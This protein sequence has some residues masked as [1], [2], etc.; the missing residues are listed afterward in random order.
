[1]SS[2]YILLLNQKYKI[3]KCTGNYS[4]LMSRY[5]TAL[6]KYKIFDYRHY[7]DTRAATHIEDEIKNKYHEKRYPN[8][9]GNKSEWYNLSKPDLLDIT[10][11]INTTEFKSCNSRPFSRK[12]EIYDT[13]TP[14]VIK[15]LY[16]NGCLKYCEFQRPVD[17]KRVNNIK[18]YIENNH[19][20][21]EFVL[22]PILL[23]RISNAG[24]HEYYIIDGQHRI[25]AI[26]KLSDF[27]NFPI[28]LCIKQDLNETQEKSAFVNINKSEP[29]PIIYLSPEAITTLLKEFK[30]KLHNKYP[31][32]VKDSSKC[33]MPNFHIDSIINILIKSDIGYEESETPFN[34]L[35]SHG[36]GTNSDDLL[37]Q[38]I[39][40]NNYIASKLQTN[41]TCV[42]FY[43]DIRRTQKRHNLQTIKKNIN[44][45]KK[46][47]HMPG[48]VKCY[49]GLCDYRKLISLILERNNIVN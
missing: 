19:T 14:T 46:A 13:K 2:I 43:N 41:S 22:P 25:E 17:K 38:F 21:S 9:N 31:Q 10:N 20:R 7:Y 15:Q 37:D 27:Y 42:N 11:L 4:K 34:I 18:S 1:M 44:K 49:L 35:Y 3:G 12:P 30:T 5:N 23:N 33:R 28:H 39:N 8:I 40:V 24:I 26:V 36:I 48:N 45:I 16:R 6:L 32:H 47:S 29:V